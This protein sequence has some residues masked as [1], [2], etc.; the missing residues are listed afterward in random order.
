MTDRE[1]AEPPADRRLPP[2][3]PISAE[4]ALQMRF[5]R[6]EY[7]QAKGW[8]AMVWRRHLDSHKPG[9]PGRLQGNDLST[10]LNNSTM[11]AQDTLADGAQTML[12]PCLESADGDL[13][14]ASRTIADLESSSGREIEADGAVRTVADARRAADDL[15][16]EIQRDTDEGYLHHRRTSLA[17]KQLSNTLMVL[18]LAAII[19]IFFDILNVDYT[20]PLSSPPEFLAA[21]FLPVILIFVQLWLAQSAGRWWNDY[22]QLDV[23]ASAGADGALRR[24]RTWSVYTTLCVVPLTALLIVR[25]YGMSIDADLGALWTVVLVGLALAIGLGAPLVKVRVIADDGS[26]SSRRRDELEL[27]LADAR[28]AIDTGVQHVR[29]CLDAATLA[30]DDYL[31]RLRPDVLQEAASSLVQAENA[32]GLFTAMVSSDD[33]HGRAGLTRRDA[34]ADD[35]D[36]KF[37]LL[38][39]A[40]DLAPRIDN[41]P[42]LVR[43]RTCREQ[44]ARERRLRERIG[45]FSGVGAPMASSPDGA[46]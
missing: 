21:M 4:R 18:D 27:A 7:D 19:V 17:W 8:Y 29:S 23:L 45:A 2:P 40:F 43:D 42:V 36:E 44:I 3:P 16:A 46:G 11:E 25:L 6:A 14:E 33:E 31:D 38:Q 5:T 15:N 10:F 13:V 9:G 39:W 35:T 26:S 41:G 34:G 28:R 22:R 24:A 32:L 30:H 1:F 20:R 37:P 12:D